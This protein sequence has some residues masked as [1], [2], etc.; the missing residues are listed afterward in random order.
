M[1]ILLF[2]LWHW[3]CLHF[4]FLKAF[5]KILD[6]ILILSLSIICYF[7]TRRKRNGSE[8]PESSCQRHPGI[9]VSGFC[10][11]IRMEHSQ[12]A[13]VVSCNMKYRLADCVLQVSLLSYCAWRPYWPQ[14]GL[15]QEVCG[16]EQEIQANHV[17]LLLQRLYASPAAWAMIG[18]IL[19]LGMAPLVAPSQGSWKS[20]NNKIGL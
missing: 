3:F 17:R 6:S 14:R 13:Q 18:H 9:W 11:Y 4:N 16:L 8:I 1:G 10:N 12:D 19:S 5:P 20:D 7:P 2:L 15:V